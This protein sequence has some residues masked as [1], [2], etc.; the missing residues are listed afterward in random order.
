MLPFA[1]AADCPSLLPLLSVQLVPATSAFD[2]FKGDMRL[3]IRAAKPAMYA[4]LPLTTTLYDWRKNAT[5]L[6]VNT[7]NTDQYNIE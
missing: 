4:P 1:A 5:Y 6:D 2:F 7:Q 3:E